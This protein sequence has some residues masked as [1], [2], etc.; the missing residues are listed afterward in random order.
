SHKE[1][2]D[3]L[4]EAWWIL[5]A[6]EFDTLFDELIVRQG[7]DNYMMWKLNSCGVSFWKERNQYRTQ[8]KDIRE[9]SDLVL[10]PNDTMDI[11]GF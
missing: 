6:D 2:Y 4:D 1:W 3:L 5:S 7:N 10:G 11:Y 8:I 9:W